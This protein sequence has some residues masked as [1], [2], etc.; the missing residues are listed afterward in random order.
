M[1]GGI[2]YLSKPGSCHECARDSCIY[3]DKECI[4]WPGILKVQGI[5]DFIYYLF[6]AEDNLFLGHITLSI[7]IECSVDLEQIYPSQCMKMH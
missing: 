4:R 7:V 2:L 5:L 3:T 6:L 1:S